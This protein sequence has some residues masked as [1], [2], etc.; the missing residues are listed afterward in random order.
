[1][2]TVLPRPAGTFA[3]TLIVALVGLVNVRE[4]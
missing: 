1:M 4:N 3:D 2:G